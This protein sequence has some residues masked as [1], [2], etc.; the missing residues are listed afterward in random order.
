MNRKHHEGSTW[1]V[2]VLKGIP[3]DFDE[4]SLFCFR[5]KQKGCQSFSFASGVPLIDEPH[6]SSTLNVLTIEAREASQGP[7]EFKCSSYTFRDRVASPLSQYS[8]ALASSACTSMACTAALRS[9]TSPKSSHH[10]ESDVQD[11]LTDGGR[12]YAD[13]KSMLL[14]ECAG[15]FTVGEAIDS[16]WDLYC[17]LSVGKTEI[18][19]RSADE[20]GFALITELFEPRNSPQE[21]ERPVGS[22]QEKPPNYVKIMS[23]GDGKPEGASILT[24]GSMEQ[25][26]EFLSQ[27]FPLS[28]SF[29]FEPS[30]F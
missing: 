21:E 7:L 16:C 12:H 30:A 13:A 10:H 5:F 14:P 4:S 17:S 18:G 22:C 1:E 11:T 27:R 29:F 9:L 6:S 28:S 3:H 19:M 25:L 24:F 8:M 15:N 2:T 20:P 26:Q 23:Y